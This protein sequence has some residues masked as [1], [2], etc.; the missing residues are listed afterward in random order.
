MISFKKILNFFFEISK[1]NKNLFHKLSIWEVMRIKNKIKTKNLWVNSV[2]TLS[3]DTVSSRGINTKKKSVIAKNYH[4]YCFITRKRATTI[5]HSI[6]A[7]CFW[8]CGGKKKTTAEKEK[9]ENERR[10][11]VINELR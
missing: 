10:K 7:T 11:K 8:C 4:Y 9:R 2:M 3:A 1:N 6:N 5:S